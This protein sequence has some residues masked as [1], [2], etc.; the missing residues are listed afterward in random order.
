MS[1]TSG[2]LG[3]LSKNDE[4]LFEWIRMVTN[5]IWFCV[6]TCQGSVKKLKEKWILILY[7]IPNVH[8][9]YLVR[10]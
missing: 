8:I 4:V 3:S 10:Q 5:Q 9:G 2:T 6:T 1:M 7:H